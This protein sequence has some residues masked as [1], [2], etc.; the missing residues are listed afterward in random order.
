MRHDLIALFILTACALGSTGLAQGT[1]RYSNRL[2]AWYWGNARPQDLQGR[3]PTGSRPVDVN[4]MASGRIAYTTVDSRTPNSPYWDP[5][6]RLDVDVPAPLVET[7]I[8][9][10]GVRP[11]ALTGYATS[12]GQ[13]VYTVA[14]E[15]ER[16]R[17][18][19]Y[20]PGNSPNDLQSWLSSNPAYR[21]YFLDRVT[22]NGASRYVMLAELTPPG[23]G[24]AT[25]H[26]DQS[27]AMIR[28]L[29]QHG[30]SFIS[31][32]QE[33]DR[34]DDRFDVIVQDFGPTERSYHTEFQMFE[35]GSSRGGEQD[36]WAGSER[37]YSVVDYPDANGVWRTARLMVDDAWRFLPLGYAPG[38]NGSFGT[39]PTL[40][41]T[42]AT[43]VRPGAT[44]ELALRL[45]DPG[46]PA[47]ML[48]GLSRARWQ[49]QVLP[50]DLGPA[51]APDCLLSVAPLATVA[52]IGNSFGQLDFALPVPATAIPGTRIYVQGLTAS[53]SANSL[54]IATS[55]PL[56]IE[57]E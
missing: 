49:G 31:A 37:V 3:I 30:T 18:W 22:I 13:L 16:G 32:I 28:G 14:S 6:W 7:G 43:D 21:P 40:S 46:R 10:F 44:V 34:G 48:F 2:T 11:V 56:L 38:C 36:L 35:F 54:G 8:R 4:M 57:I 19:Q 50:L 53:P 52:G 41:A 42:T 29:A 9:S 27:V 33:S 5:N 24:G 51:G 20:V 23:S 26:F 17:N 45:T 1:D 47:L 12:N 39:P 15:S 55:T 25:L